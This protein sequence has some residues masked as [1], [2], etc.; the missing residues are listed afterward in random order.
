MFMFIE[1]CFFFCLSFHL[2]LSFILVCFF[3]LLVDVSFTSVTCCLNVYVNVGFIPNLKESKVFYEQTCLV[4]WDIFPIQ[5]IISIQPG[6]EWGDS[7]KMSQCC[8][9]H[10][11]QHLLSTRCGC[12]LWLNIVNINQGGTCT[13]SQK[14][15]S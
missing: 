11:C 8:I 6:K 12:Y 1:S 5:L 2:S 15:M 9:R 10:S 4:L 3:L 7:H 14:Q 13:L